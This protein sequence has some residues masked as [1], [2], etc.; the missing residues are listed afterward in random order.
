MSGNRVLFDARSVRPGMTGIGNFAFNLLRAYPDVTA[1]KPGVLLPPGSPHCGDFPGMTVHEA[2][3]DLTKHPQTDAY[4]QFALTGF[5][6][7]N[8]YGAFVS[9]DG[10]V[11][12]FHAGIRTYSWFY[13]MAHLK[14]RGTHRARF[15]ALM[16]MSRWVALRSGAGILTI[17]ETVRE[18]ILAAYKL[19][20]S[21]VSV[22]YPSDS[23]LAACDP[24][25]VPGVRP[26]YLLSVGIT[27]P[28]KNLRALLDAYARLRRAR[29]DLQLVLTGRP[30]R[31]RAEIDATDGE[32]VLNAGF[33]DRNGLR[34]LHEQA[35]SLVFPSL[36]EG[37]GIPL[38]D[39]AR[40]GVPVACSDLAVFREVM[41]S[42]A[43]YFNPADPDSI[44][45]GIL[46]SLAEPRDSDALGRLAERFSWEHSARKL[47][48]LLTQ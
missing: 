12:Y 26:P 16:W 15:T 11:P 20:A 10:R 34:Y 18:E 7:R 17:S 9:F 6:K 28:R 24:R 39:S 23:G 5:C 38:L 14:I 36:D 47:A 29:P 44:A 37:F 48:D 32:G 33:V 4:E 40:A 19:P 1:D 45:E 43:T 31:I 22:I 3:Y 8:G 27:N 13:D 25:P 2:P 42:H 35:A 41:G 30:D 46:R 21:R